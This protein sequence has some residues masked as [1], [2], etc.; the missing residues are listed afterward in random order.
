MSRRNWAVLCCVGVLLCSAIAL[1]PASST[2]AVIEEGYYKETQGKCGDNIKWE[3]NKAEKTLTISGT[4]AMYD[5]REGLWQYVS[6]DLMKNYYT[7][8][9]VE[10]K[11]SIT[12]IGNWAFAY[13]SAKTINL[14]DTLEGIGEHAF[15]FAKIGSLILPDSVNNISS[16]AFESCNNLTEVKLPVG[17]EKIP[18]EMFKGLK[19]L[20][21][22]V[23]PD[24]LKEF[25][26]TSFSGCTNYIPDL[27][28]CGVLE[29]V[30]TAGLG[31]IEKLVIPDSVKTVNISSTVKNVVLGRSVSEFIASGSSP[32]AI[33]VV[34]SNPYLT[35]QDDV[36]YSKDMKT[37]IFYPPSKTN[38][39]LVV[40]SSVEE[41][42][43]INNNYLTEVTVPNTVKACGGI[44]SSNL[45]ILNVPASLS[46]MSSLSN[47]IACV[48]IDYHTESYIQN[49][50]L[51]KY[52][53]KYIDSVVASKLSDGS[54]KI[55]LNFNSAVDL[56]SIRV[57]SQYNLDDIQ[58][59]TSNDFILSADSSDY[60]K[61]FLSVDVG[62][63]DETPPSEY[64]Y[65]QKESLLTKIAQM[66]VPIFVILMVI[67]GAGGTAY[68]VIVIRQ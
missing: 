15:K 32:S 4:G 40:P 41:I 28:N 7:I 44:V 22:V 35:V 2:D 60:V 21:S 24:A 13:C 19:S 37:M 36:L 42:K 51:L 26:G 66:L 16:D 11:G 3:F 6:Q 34:S 17:M 52:Y 45:E 29:S 38:T 56:S 39:S 61:V 25:S 33:E 48:P 53:S 10:F 50:I 63:G 62:E 8:S 54:Y 58:S 55:H 49:G 46:N 65:E 1:F 18:Y 67:F 14:P 27:S 59:S 30:T 57:G 43:K 20:K 68:Y 31:S 5:A 12:Y 47:E 9:H 23:L 64:H